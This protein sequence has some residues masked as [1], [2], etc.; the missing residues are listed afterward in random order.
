[1]TRQRQSDLGYLQA[2]TRARLRYG[3]SVL[4]IVLVLLATGGFAGW[5]RLQLPPDPTRVTTLQDSGTGSLRSA[6]DNAPSGST[7]TFDASLEGTLLLTDVLHIGKRLSIRAPDA[8][9][10]TMNGSPNAEFGVRV[11]PT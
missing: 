1:R 10:V 2:S 4:T 7:I 3:I 11:S 8:G 5:L 9:H 6:I